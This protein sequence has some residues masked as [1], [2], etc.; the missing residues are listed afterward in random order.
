MKKLRKFEIEEQYLEI[1]DSL[2]YP[3]VSYTKDSKKVW[4]MEKPQSYFIGTF[5]T[6]KEN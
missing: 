1:K 5:E 3:S 4:V 6:T 2:K